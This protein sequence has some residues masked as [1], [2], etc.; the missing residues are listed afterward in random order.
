L[1]TL[2]WHLQAGSHTQLLAA[3]GLYE[4]LWAKQRRVGEGDEEVAG[5]EAPEEVAGEFGNPTA[6]GAGN[7]AA[8]RGQH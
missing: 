5:A 6:Q 4:Q 8:A 7:V 3:G 1:T 2:L